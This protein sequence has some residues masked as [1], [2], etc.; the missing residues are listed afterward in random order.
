MNRI[1]SCILLALIPI[2]QLFGQDVENSRQISQRVSTTQRVGTTDIT[3][4]YHSPLADG[5]IIFGGIVPFDFTLDGKE[6]AWRAGANQRTQ[7]EFSH[8]VT[9]EG[10]SLTAGKYGFVVLVSE[11]EWTMVFSSDMSWAVSNTI[12]KTM[13]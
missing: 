9:I 10:K 1:S 11:K 8:D 5:Q 13:C 12:R 7:I 3:I 4:V 6:Y 2:A